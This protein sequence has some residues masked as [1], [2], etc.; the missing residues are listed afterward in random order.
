MCLRDLRLAARGVVATTSGLAET[1]ARD[2]RKAA[3]FYA[4]FGI[5]KA[6]FL[7]GVPFDAEAKEFMA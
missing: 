1:L 4:R 3:A 7:C 6:T 2:G 5:T